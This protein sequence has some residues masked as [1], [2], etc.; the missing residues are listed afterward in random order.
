MPF[1][2][3]SVFLEVEHL[4][5][6]PEVPREMKRNKLHLCFLP[7]GVLA[8]KHESKGVSLSNAFSG[9][10]KSNPYDKIA[11]IIFILINCPSDI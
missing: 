2:S 8:L 5:R 10:Y 9:Y 1:F 11:I 4:L 6:F 7:F 3:L